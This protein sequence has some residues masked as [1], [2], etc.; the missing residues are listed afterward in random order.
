MTIFDWFLLIGA[1]IAFLLMMIG[2]FYTFSIPL[3]FYFGGRELEQEVKEI[4]ELL[5]ELKSRRE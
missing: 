3:H 5:E 2:L 1:G 4:R